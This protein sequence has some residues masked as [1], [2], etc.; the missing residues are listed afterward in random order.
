MDFEHYFDETLGIR[1]EPKHPKKGEYKEQNGR[2][3]SKKTKEPPKRV[4]H[5]WNIKFLT[6]PS[7]PKKHIKYFKFIRKK[8][9]SDHC[10]LLFCFPPLPFF[11]DMKIL[12]PSLFWLDSD[13]Y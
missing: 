4:N 11:Q 7:F 9:I 13:H 10:S 12:C 5:K 8:C 3:L 6:P 2:T 1:N